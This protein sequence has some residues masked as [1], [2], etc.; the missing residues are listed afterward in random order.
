MRLRRRKDKRGKRRRERKGEREGRQTGRKRSRTSE[1][2]E[3]E[4]GGKGIREGEK[5]EGR[6]GK[7]K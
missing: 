6:K 4:E 5:E 7:E 3:S 1:G 2:M